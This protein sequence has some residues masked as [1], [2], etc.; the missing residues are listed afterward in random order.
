MVIINCWH[1]WG[2]YINILANKFSRMVWMKVERYNDLISC[3]YFEYLYQPILTTIPL[4]SH[5]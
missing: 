4:Q 5:H 2:K 1:Y 3:Y